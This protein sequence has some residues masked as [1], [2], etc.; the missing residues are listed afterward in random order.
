MCLIGFT[1]LLLSSAGE[2]L[3]LSYG[4]MVWT[5]EPGVSFELPQHEQRARVL[6]SHFMRE[7]WE[8]R[9]L[10]VRAAFPSLAHNPIM[11]ADELAGL[12][13][14]EDA[15]ARIVIDEREV[16]HGPF[17]EGDFDDLGSEKAEDL[18]TLLVNDVERFHPPAHTIA[19]AFSFIPTWRHDDVQVSLCPPGGA[20]IGAHVDSYD[21]FLVQGAG[22]REWSIMA[23][24]YIGKS[25][26][27]A[28]LKD[29][30]IEKG[31]V[32]NNYDMSFSQSSAVRSLKDEAFEA[33][34]T[35][36]LEPGDMLYLPPRIPHRGRSLCLEEERYGS[37][38]VRKEDWACSTISVGFRSPS[39]RELIARF[40]EHVCDS[41]EDS[42]LDFRH[43]SDKKTWDAGR[44]PPE[45]VESAKDRIRASFIRAVESKDF[46]TFLGGT[47][48][49]PQRTS[50][51]D[52]IEIT[53][54]KEREVELLPEDIRKMKLVRRL[55]TKFVYIEDKIIGNE[56]GILFVDGVSF[57]FS[58]SSASFVKLLCDRSQ[59]RRD[60]VVGDIAREI[61][62]SNFE[63]HTCKLIKSLLSY[64]FLDCTK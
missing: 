33:T 48:T 59:H 58:A 5:L 40:S 14:D 61:G 12:A 15:S 23:D 32:S 46:L 36:V 62:T 25:E 53:D 20:G 22:R 9:P 35:W 56:G 16:V 26:E 60:I 50:V 63:K 4:E 44:I 57:D 11:K 51:H 6:H 28:L 19:E 31:A 37:T 41:T 21:V 47:L 10:L 30:R 45:V 42:I 64:G 29:T 8:R 13:C 34:H 3:S 1:V 24:K 43:G 52:S 17:D 55:G 54:S 27:E 18:W 39:L 7:Y 2:S 49:E 38:T